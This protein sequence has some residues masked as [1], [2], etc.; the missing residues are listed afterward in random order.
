MNNIQIVK[1][2]MENILV[3]RN[4]IPCWVFQLCYDEYSTDEMPENG[5]EG[6]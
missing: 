1:K 5:R 4:C 2:K 6:E 3:P